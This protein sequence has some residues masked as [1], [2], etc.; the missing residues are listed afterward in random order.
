MSLGRAVFDRDKM[1]RSALADNPRGTRKLG[2]G[3]TPDI[4]AMSFPFTGSDSTRPPPGRKELA[5][6]FRVSKAA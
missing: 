1:R 6:M 4:V 3:A 2:A 5:R